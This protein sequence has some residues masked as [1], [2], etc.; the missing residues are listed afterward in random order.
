MAVFDLLALLILVGTSLNNA[1]TLEIINI[2]RIWAYY[3]A[4]ECMSIIRVHVPFQ[5]YVEMPILN[6]F[7]C[8]SMYCAVVLTIERYIMLCHPIKHLARRKRSQVKVCK[9]ANRNVA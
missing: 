3:R 6:T 8:A 7:L 9:V 4:R 1:G 5:A 2:F